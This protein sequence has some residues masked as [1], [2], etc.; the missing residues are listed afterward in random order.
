VSAGISWTATISTLIA[1][2]RL[3]LPAWVMGRGMAVY[4]M[5]FTGCQALGALLWGLVAGWWGL[6]ATFVICAGLS[7]VAVLA[8]LVW[9]VADAGEHAP[10]PVVYWAEARVSSDPD[11]DAGPV[12]VTVHYTIAPDDETA[13][14]AAMRS[15][16]SSRLRTGAIR[17][18]LY[19]DAEHP[20][21]F[22]EQFRVGSWQEHLRQHEGRLTATDRD[23]EQAAINYSN[24]PTT[25]YHLI[26]P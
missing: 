10:D 3:F 16:R 6:T 7:A 5:V 23:I 14:L 20:D 25:A 11:P 9:R 2:L 17:W 4:T 13:W 19:R 26:P 22:V 8:G 21:R 18:E 15:L 12:M 1:E 24:P